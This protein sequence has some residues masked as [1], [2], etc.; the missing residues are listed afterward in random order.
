MFAGA[1]W[2]GLELLGKATPTLCHS[3]HLRLHPCKFVHFRCCWHIWVAAACLPYLEIA[4]LIQW[5]NSSKSFNWW[6]L[7]LLQ[8]LGLSR[9]SS[10][11]VV[12]GGRAPGKSSILA[13]PQLSISETF[14]WS[15]APG[16]SSILVLRWFL[17]LI[18]EYI[19][20]FFEGSIGWLLLLASAAA[21]MAVLLLL[22]LACCLP[23]AC[24]CL[25]LLAC[26]PAYVPACVLACL[27]AQTKPAM[28]SARS[29]VKGFTPTRNRRV[30]RTT[31]F[32]RPVHDLDAHCGHRFGCG[33]QG[34]R[35]IYI[36]IYIDR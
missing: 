32:L 21:C 13:S 7:K 35:Y 26:L 8:A 10:L 1:C 20:S 31:N 15:R 27:L 3:G 23:A 14:N 19:R 34:A 25:L 2:S 33:K 29:G 18:F 36:Y 22:L 17:E 11:K 16:K 4:N 12:S 9:I 5:L 24:C 30:D 28:L 6:Q